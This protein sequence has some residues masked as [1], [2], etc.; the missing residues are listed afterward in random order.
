MQR[1]FDHTHTQHAADGVLAGL[2]LV[3]VGDWPPPPGGVAIHLHALRDAARKAGAEVR[4]LDIGKGAHQTAGVWHAG[5]P[6]R[7]ATALARTF[8]WGDLVH[9]HTSGANPKSWL[10]TAA[11]GFTA[12][13]GKLKSLVTFHSGHGPNYLSTPARAFSARLALSS[14]DRVVCVN[15]EISKAL[16]R[17]GAASGRHVLAPAFGREG[18]TPGELPPSLVAPLREGR[19]LVTAMLAPGRD[20]GQP[21]LLEAFATVRSTHAD[22]TLVLYGPGTDSQTTRDA[23]RL[24]DAEPVLTLGA[25]ERPQALALLRASTVFVRPTRVDGDAVS[26]RE[27]LALGARVVATRAG[28]RPD[29]VLLCDPGD[30]GA[31]AG[32]LDRA[33]REGRPESPPHG[34]QDGIDTILDV[35]ARLVRRPTAQRRKAA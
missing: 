4:V 17:I 2:R 28:H 26:V 25:I 24:A 22:A 32:A 12:R 31:L 1:E 23:I 33:L 14:Y 13:V 30:A 10:V 21:E 34:G 19:T 16:S 6:A 29:G 5:T 7:F 27:A 20:Y 35:Y 8:A 11:V 3:L 15:R 9:L 18:L